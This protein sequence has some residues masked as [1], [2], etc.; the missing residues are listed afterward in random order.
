MWIASIRLGSLVVKTFVYQPMDRESNPEQGK[1]LCVVGVIRV[2]IDK[3]QV[4]SR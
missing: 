4:M 1:K 3:K 2:K